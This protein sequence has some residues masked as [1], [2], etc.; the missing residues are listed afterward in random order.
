MFRLT[1]FKRPENEDCH[2]TTADLN[3]MGAISTS[4]KRPITKANFPRQFAVSMFL[5][6]IQRPVWRPLQYNVSMVALSETVGI[7]VN[8][9]IYRVKIK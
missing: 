2:Q 8:H 7:S 1:A 9:S 5:V 3:P 4:S 6:R